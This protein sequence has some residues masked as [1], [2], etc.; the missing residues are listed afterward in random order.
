MKRHILSGLLALLVLTHAAQAFSAD[1]DPMVQEPQAGVS[2]QVQGGP[3][4]HVEFGYAPNSNGL[5]FQLIL[6]DL[7]GAELPLVFTTYP[8][9]ES[10]TSRELYVGPWGIANAD[11]D[12]LNCDSGARCRIV[13][14]FYGGQYQAFY[15]LLELR[16]T[17]GDI[18]GHVP[19]SAAY[20]TE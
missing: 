3:G 20:Y 14:S 19:P 12:L 9:G 13:V 8:S 16:T 2:R 1:N 7:T 11:P 5:T 18:V 4:Y 15:A 17:R 6:T 10:S